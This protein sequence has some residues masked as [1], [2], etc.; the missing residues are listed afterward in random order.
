[1]NHFLERYGDWGFVAGSAEGIGAAWCRALAAKGM[2][3][4]ML[5]RQRDKLEKFAEEIRKIFLVEVRTLHLSLGEPGTETMVMK[6]VKELECR[7]LIYNAT[8]GPVKPFLDNSKE[9]LD[10]YIDVN[11]RETLQLVYSFTQYLKA[12]GNSGGI[13]LM[14]SLAGLWGTR[15]VAPYGA[16]KSFNLLL[17][18]GLHHELKGYGIDVMACIAGATATPGYLG[19]DPKYG[20]IKPNVMKPEDVATPALEKLGKRPYYIPGFSNR[21][22][23]ML[24]TRILPRRISSKIFNNTMKTMYKHKYPN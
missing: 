19:S 11:C 7:L 8:Y 1:M 9:E 5:D 4:L 15:L 12:K 20:W 24:F 21:L 18:E 2:N 23:Y 10:L 13:I 16:S 3:I 17:A 6:A 22:T 14:A